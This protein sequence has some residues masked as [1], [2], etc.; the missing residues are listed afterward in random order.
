MRAEELRIGNIIEDSIGIIEIGKSARI[1]FADVYKPVPLTEEWIKKFN[2][3]YEY[4]LKKGCYYN[5]NIQIWIYK[6][7]RI[8]LRIDG[9]DFKDHNWKNKK[10]KYVHQLQ[11]LFFALTGKELELS[12]PISPVV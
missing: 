1:E 2:L 11:N 3:K 10:Y 5:D 8:D 4:A 7:G 12:S 6:N 9:I